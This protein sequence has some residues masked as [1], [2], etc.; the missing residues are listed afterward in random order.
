MKPTA[1]YIIL[2]FIM[3]CSN[4][5][6]KKNETKSIDTLTQIKLKTSNF[7]FVHLD[8]LS[9]TGDFN[10]DGKIDT[11][12]ENTISGL[13]KLPIDSIPNYGELDSLARFFDKVESVLTLTLINRKCDTLHFGSPAKGLYCLIN[14]GDNNNDKKD[15]IALVIDYCDFSNCNSCLIYTL[16]ENKWIELKTF[17]IH[18]NAFEFNGDSKPIFKQ[19]K[20]FLEYR[21]NKWFYIDYN[22]WFNAESDKDTIL[23][24]LKIKKGC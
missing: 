7:K 13:N 17:K 9:I 6:S 5:D 21:K 4:F 12:V 16:C 23:K 11:L 18:E 3:S 1:F 15:E 20:G 8:K 10:G 2:V 14:I 19:I 24:M 22:D